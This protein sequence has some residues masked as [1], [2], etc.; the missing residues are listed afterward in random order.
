[1][2]KNFRNLMM[3]LFGVTFLVS[4]W[5]VISIKIDYKAGMSYGFGS[6]Q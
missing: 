5:Q 6:P 3:V 4:A 2:K 1:M